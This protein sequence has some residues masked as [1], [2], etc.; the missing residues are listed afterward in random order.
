VRIDDPA[1][2]V[3]ESEPPRRLAYTFHTFT[4]EFAASVGFSDELQATLAGE[5]RS[6]VTFEIEPLVGKVKLTVVHDDFD[7][8]STVLDLVSGGWPA[9]IANLKTLLETG[10]TLPGGT[11]S[12]PN[13]DR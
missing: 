10:E 11:P 3:L 6:K 9:V 4:P 12:R 13:Q 2:V 5:R 1:Q 8:G 7:A